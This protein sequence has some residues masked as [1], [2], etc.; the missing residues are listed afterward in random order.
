MKKFLSHI[1]LSTCLVSSFYVVEAKAIDHPD[2]FHFAL[3]E[4]ENPYQWGEKDNSPDSNQDFQEKEK[5]REAAARQ[6]IDE[7]KKINVQ[8]VM[9]IIKNIEEEKETSKSSSRKV[10]SVEEIGGLSIEDLQK[11][12]FYNPIS[13][14]FDV[15]KIDGVFVFVP[16]EY[17]EKAGDKE[18]LEDYTKNST[19]SRYKAEYS[20]LNERSYA[21]GKHYDY[22]Y[23]MRH[24]PLIVTPEGK[25]IDYSPNGKVLPPK[26]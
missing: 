14:L 16:T 2:G 10:K 15:F 20:P 4:E 1:L 12:S 6:L 24:H 17:L 8:Q 13:H 18:A 5:N 23:V 19:I 21:L 22:D 25:V 11:S 3:S 7:A 9:T 26:E